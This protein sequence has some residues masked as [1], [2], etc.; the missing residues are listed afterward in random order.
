MPSGWMPDARHDLR[1][2]P[3]WTQVAQQD[4]QRQGRKGSQQWTLHR[5]THRTARPLRGAHA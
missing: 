3:V 5:K 4:K 2:R 1:M